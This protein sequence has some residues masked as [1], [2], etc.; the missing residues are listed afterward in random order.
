[1][2]KKILIGIA[3]VSLVL[4]AG[5]F[6]GEI[7]DSTYTAEEAQEISENWIREEAPTFTERGGEALTHINTEEVEEFTFEVTFDFESSFAGYGIVEEDEMAAQV[8]TPHTI[9]VTVE[10]GEVVN[11]VTDEMFD[12]INGEELEDGED[13]NEENAETTSVNLFFVEVVDGVENIVPVEREIEETGDLEEAT[14]E[15]LLEGVN[16]DEA[17]NFSTSIPE[18]TELLSFELEN[19]VATVDFSSDL[20]PGGG[21]AWITAIQDQITSTLEQFDSVDEVVILV[22]GEEDALQP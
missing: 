15:A 2:N 22:E 19:G 9:L 7:E 18:G 14:L 13:E 4:V 21:S 11:A 8:I 6:L 16:E 5:Y 20:K 10:E 17:E 12:E 3:I 1:M